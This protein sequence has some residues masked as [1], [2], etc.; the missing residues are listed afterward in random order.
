MLGAS[1]QSMEASVN[2]T[3]HVRNSRL[4]PRTLAS[5]PVAGRMMALAAR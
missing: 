5:H 4:R 2:T 1:P 3:V